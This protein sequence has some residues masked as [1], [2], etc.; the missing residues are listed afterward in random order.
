M[1]KVCGY[2]LVENLPVSIFLDSF[3]SFRDINEN[4][5]ESDLK[6]QTEELVSSVWRL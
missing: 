6:Y 1:F 2:F 4:L 3:V 5:N